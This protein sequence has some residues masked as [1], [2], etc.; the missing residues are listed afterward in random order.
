MSATA[1]NWII[2]ILA[3]AV[4]GAIINKQDTKAAA[5]PTVAVAAPT[6]PAIP[7]ERDPLVVKTPIVG[8]PT[9]ACDYEDDRNC[10]WDAGQRDLGKGYSYWVDRNGTVTYLDPQLND[11]GARLKWQADK[12]K[13]G[14]ERYGAVG[15]HQNCYALA[16]AV[17]CWDGF[18]S[19]L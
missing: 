12:K 2:G 15:G 1:K 17:E 3:F 11:A 10:F 9:R 7:S 14:W 19:T 16:S 5:Q 13:A 6:Q 8:L 4:V 18:R